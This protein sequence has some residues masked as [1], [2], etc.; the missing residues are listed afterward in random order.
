MKLR[1]L[2]QGLRF[3]LCKRTRPRIGANIYYLLITYISIC[4]TFPL[5]LYT[6]VAF[7][8]CYIRKNSTHRISS[9]L[10]GI[11]STRPHVSASNRRGKCHFVRPIRI[12]ARESFGRDAAFGKLMTPQRLL[13]FPTAGEVSLTRGDISACPHRETL[14]SLGPETPPVRVRHR[15][16]QPFH[17][18]AIF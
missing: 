18:A 12:T 15:I 7:K 13:T 14:C 2:E 1:I 6:P 5:H 8:N 10:N 3:A 4:Y 16:T 9:K 17:R 11:F